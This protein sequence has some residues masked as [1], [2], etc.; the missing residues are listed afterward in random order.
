MPRPEIC[1]ARCTDCG[2]DFPRSPRRFL[3]RLANDL[4]R[5]D[6]FAAHRLLI[7]PRSSRAPAVVR[8]QRNFLPQ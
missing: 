7:A 1:C 5:F 8:R 3:S 2:F 4:P 6:G